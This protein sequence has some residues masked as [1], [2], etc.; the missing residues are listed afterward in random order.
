MED[1]ICSVTTL[2]GFTYAHVC[3]VRGKSY[4]HITCSDSQCE[5]TFKI[6]QTVSF[7]QVVLKIKI[8]QYMLGISVILPQGLCDVSF[9]CKMPQY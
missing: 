9:T 4:Q 8:C 6:A 3:N 1:Q 7:I 2:T 5:S